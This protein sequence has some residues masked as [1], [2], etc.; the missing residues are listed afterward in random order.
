MIMKRLFICVFAIMA[1]SGQIY[2]KDAYRDK[3]IGLSFPLKLA[4]F[5]F[6]GHHNYEKPGLGYSVRY[7]DDRLFKIDI[8]VYDNT[9]KDIGDGSSSKRVG[10]EFNSVLAIFPYLEKNGKYR[11][12]KELK[13]GKKKYGTNGVE[14]LWAQYQYEQSPGEGVQYYGKRIS[15]T[16]LTAKKGKFIKVRLTFKK[17]ELN[18]RE[19]DTKEFMKEL[20]KMLNGSS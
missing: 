13:K 19:K 8:Y 15:N 6:Q 10:D 1:F 17:N 7:Q 5:E 9:Y 18:K 12:V 20:S 2:A 14:F 3:E 4:G 16:Y 11:N